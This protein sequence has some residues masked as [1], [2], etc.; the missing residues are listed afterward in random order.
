MKPALLANGKLK[1]IEMVKIMI[2]SMTGFGRGEARDEER[3]VVIEIKCVNHRYFDTYLKMPKRL[4]ELEDRLVKQ[5][6]KSVV[7]GRAEVY[8]TVQNTGSS[9]VEVVCNDSLAETYM[10]ALSKLGEKIGISKQVSLETIIKM[11]DVISVKAPDE[12]IEAMWKL[13]KPA[14]DEAL[15]SVKRMRMTEGENTACDIKERIDTVEKNLACVEASA[16]DIVMTY[17]ERLQ[18]RL[19]EIEKS[20]SVDDNRLATELIIYS[21]KVDVSE[22]ITRAKSHII[23]LRELLESSEPIGRKMDF[24][25]QELNREVNTIGSKASASPVA[26]QVVDMKVELEKVREQVQNI[27]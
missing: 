16:K 8:V 2:E 4:N 18:E 10:T 23:Q 21:D 19:R 26:K 1:N 24:L 14:L 15:S 12:D 17:K 22:E 6:K 25:M 7:R 3:T 20:I 9:Q 27:L 11:P 13:L 5:V